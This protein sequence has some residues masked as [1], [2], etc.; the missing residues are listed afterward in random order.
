MVREGEELSTFLRVE[1]MGK[2]SIEENT[3]RSLWK[4][5]LPRNLRT[6]VSMIVL[7]MARCFCTYEEQLSWLP[8]C[9]SREPTQTSLKTQP[10]EQWGIRWPPSYCDKSCTFIRHRRCTGTIETN[11]WNNEFIYFGLLLANQFAK[12]KYQLTINPGDGYSPCLA[13]EPVT[14]PKK[15]VSI[16]SWVHVFVGVFTGC[17][18][19]DVPGLMKYRCTMQDLP[20]RGHNWRFPVFETGPCYFTSMGYWYHSLGALALHTEPGPCKES[21][22][23]CKHSKAYV[24][25]LYT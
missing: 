2:S 15:I 22:N 23:L 24:Q 14:K 5:P 1:K 8:L 10:P 19:R 9:E 7:C 16:D 6:L 11:T 18:P 12:V 13:L 3:Q 25:S 20:E 17:F 21:A 4:I